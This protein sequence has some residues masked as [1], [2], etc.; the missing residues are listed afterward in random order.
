[1][2]ELLIVGS[3][4]DVITVKV[5]DPQNKIIIISPI[6]W[7]LKSI[8]VYEIRSVLMHAPFFF[9]TYEFG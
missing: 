9:D 7:I 3:L 1:M 6:N 4:V 5:S 8:S 2:N